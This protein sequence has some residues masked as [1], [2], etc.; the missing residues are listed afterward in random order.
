MQRQTRGRRARRPHTGTEQSHQQDEFVNDVRL[1]LYVASNAPGLRAR[2][3]ALL[4][5]APETDVCVCVCRLCL[6][7][8]RGGHRPEEVFSKYRSHIVRRELDLDMR[9]MKQRESTAPSSGQLM[10]ASQGGARWPAGTVDKVARRVHTSY[11]AEVLR[12]HEPHGESSLGVVRPKRSAERALP[13]VDHAVRLVPSVT[14][15][16]TT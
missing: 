12:V 13:A 3:G 7:T 2:G 16:C 5:V 15:A 11:T 4:D 6:R 1:V 10:W 14:P 9:T 8:P